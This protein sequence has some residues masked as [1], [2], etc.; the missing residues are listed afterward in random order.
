MTVPELD[1]ICL[2][3]IPYSDI[4][5]IKVIRPGRRGLFRIEGSF[6]IYLKN[7]T[8]IELTP[9][10]PFDKQAFHWGPPTFQTFKQE[11]LVAFLQ[12]VAEK[13]P[14]LRKIVHV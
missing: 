14:V 7:E 11:E 1:K 5:Q 13:A 6:L 10:K 2:Y 12:E 4:E 9:F 8:M 3:V